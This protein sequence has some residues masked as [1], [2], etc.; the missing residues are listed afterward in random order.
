MWTKTRTREARVH[1][2]KQY[3]S[4]LLN[5]KVVQAFLARPR[6]NWTY[7]KE[8]PRKSIEAVVLPEFDD[9]QVEP[10]THQLVCMALGIAHP[11]FEL[12]LDMGL[13]KTAI[14]LNLLQY[15][16]Q[17]SGLE[18]TLVLVPSAVNVETWVKQ[19]HRHRSNLRY[20]KLLGTQDERF[21]L[22]EE[23]A[24]VY[25]MNYAG[26]MVYMA[27]LEEKKKGDRKINKMTP[28]RQLVQDFLQ[29]FNGVVF[30]ESH[31]LGNPSSLV[32]RLCSRLSKRCPFRYGMTGTPFGRDPSRLWSQFHLVDHGDT[33]GETLAVFRQAFFHS[34]VNFWGGAEW[35]FDAAKETQLHQLLQHRSIRYEDQECQDLPPLSAPE[36]L[37]ISMTEEQKIYYKRVVQKVKEVRGD[38]RSLESIFIRMRQITAGFVGFKNEADERLEVLFKQNPKIDALKEVLECVPVGSKVVI[39]HEFLWSGRLICKALDALS[40]KY[41]RISGLV[42]G[43]KLKIENYHQFLEDPETQ[44]LVANTAAAGTGVDELQMV[45][46]FVLFYELPTDPKIYR[47]AVKR[48]HRPGQQNRVYV[49]ILEMAR[50]VDEK[51]WGFIEE[52][53]DLFS[54]ICNGNSSAIEQL[55]E[56]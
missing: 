11:Q 12:L 45:S 8:L 36:R 17:N 24:D 52:G 1:R 35:Q 37:S 39:Y 38:F 43:A 26:L 51:A 30:D 16:M 31:L 41:A 55:S 4:H 15:H 53:K 32:Y 10:W 6:D 42:R 3:L 54:A 21:Q 33:L 56:E 27:E 7:L 18:S 50:S 29:R 23:P 28:N 5:P 19:I 47:Q 14:V 2:T 20:V 40:I 13:G 46:R 48:I 49:Y 34:K 9:F 22:L 44:V 25:L